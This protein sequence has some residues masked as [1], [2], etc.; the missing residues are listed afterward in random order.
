M[1]LVANKVDLVHQRKV[2][3]E[4]GR[5]LASQLRIGYME[6]SAKSPPLNVDAAFHEIVR[7]VNKYPTDEQVDEQRRRKIKQANKRKC[8]LL[9]IA[10]FILNVVYFRQN[11]MFITMAKM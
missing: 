6:T 1:L 5:E 9:W 4:K 2:S 8:A 11:A 3:E 7:I 10:I